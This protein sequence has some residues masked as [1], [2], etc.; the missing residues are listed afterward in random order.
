MDLL[1][2]AN[3]KFSSKQKW[4]EMDYHVQNG[5]DVAHKYV[6]MFCNT[7]HFTALPFFGT[8]T[9]PHGII[10]LINHYHIQFDPKLVHII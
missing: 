8:H 7:D 9:K 4:T 6:K 10:G 3:A 2:K 5:A 1:V